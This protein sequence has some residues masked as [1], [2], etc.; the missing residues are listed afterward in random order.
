VTRPSLDLGNYRCRE[1]RISLRPSATRPLPAFP[2]NRWRLPADGFWG[3][4]TGWCAE[5]HRPGASV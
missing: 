1:N 5:A 3:P 4:F 2:A